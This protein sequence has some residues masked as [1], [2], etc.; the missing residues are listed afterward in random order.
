MAEAA[1]QVAAQAAVLGRVCGCDGGGCV[2]SHTPG[3]WSATDCSSGG[4]IVH[5]G[6]G[7]DLKT[8]SLQVFPAADA[9]LIAAAPEMIDAL[10]LIMKEHG[11]SA[12]HDCLDNGEPE[13]AWCIAERIIVKAEGKT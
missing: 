6:V 11:P 3:P 12:Y 8:Q 2:V 10:K 1:D 4:K 13:C 5:R 7:P 9:D